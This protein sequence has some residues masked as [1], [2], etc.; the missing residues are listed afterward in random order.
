VLLAGALPVC[1]STVTYD[2]G[3]LSGG[4]SPSGV[5]P[6]LEATF[7][8]NGQPSDTVQ[9]TIS[10]GNLSGNEFVSCWYFNLNP[11]LDPTAL[12]FSVSGSSGS[13]T[14]PTIQKGAD[15]Y[16]AGQDGKF[17]LLL[18]FSTGSGAFTA[19]DSLTFTIT[20]ITGLTAD[21]FNSLSTAAGGIASYSSAAHIG[22]IGDGASGWINPTTSQFNS[23]DDGPINQRSVPD[24]G[25]TLGLLGASLLA[26]EGLRRKL[27]GRPSVR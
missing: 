19:G 13:F 2:F 14:D 8:D 5:P 12:N 23:F 26:I 7:S 17:D 24:G 21:D 22:G 11:A 1:A 3:Q 25:A 16:K 15:S 6:W 20:G 9:L 18:G 10:A 27:Q 4:T